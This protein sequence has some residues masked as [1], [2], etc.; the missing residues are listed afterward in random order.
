MRERI[1]EV[2][3]KPNRYEFAILFPHLKGYAIYWSVVK[4]KWC[5]SVRC[6][7]EEA[8]RIEQEFQGIRTYVY[9]DGKE[10]KS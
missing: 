4:Q 6:T 1:I 7:D 9:T 5:I 10:I 2:S 8:K 3:E